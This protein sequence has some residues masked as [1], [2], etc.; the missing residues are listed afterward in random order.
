MEQEQYDFVVI[1]AGLSGIDAA[2]RL[3]TTLPECTYTILEARDRIGGTWSFFNYP[4]I[5]ADSALT[6]FGL[7]WRP[8]LEDKDMAD[9]AR[10]RQY[11]ED[12]A[13]DE[14]I[15]KNIQLNHKLTAAHW[16]SEDQQWTLHVDARGIQ[17]Q[18]RAHWVISCAGY[19]AYDKLFNAEIPGI[20]RK[21]LMYLM[22]EQLP[23]NVPVDVHFNPRYSPFEQRVGICPDGDFFKALYQD[24]CDIVT[25]TIRT[26]EEDGILTDA[27]DK[28]EADIIITATGL[29]VQL[30]G[31]H[32]KMVGATSAV[33]VHNENLKQSKPVVNQSSTYFVKAEKRLP[34]ATGKSPCR[35]NS[36][37]HLI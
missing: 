19:Y 1:G 37:L 20:R 25:S 30:L 13:R 31:G 5:R 11:I 3:K 26:V 15:D 35:L 17:K 2:Y 18:Y 23:K 29:Y 6:V 21:L 10:I 8:W 12:A 36:V 9:G 32:M 14:G 28:L 27:G 33:P 4:G 24:N 7:P 22:K 34:R 16:A